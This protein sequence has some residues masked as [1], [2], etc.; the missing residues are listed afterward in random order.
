MTPQHAIFR[1]LFAE[2]KSISIDTYD[3]LPDFDSKYPFIYVGE[4]INTTVVNNDLMGQVAQTIHIYAERTQRKR[5]DQLITQLF[6][7]VSNLREVYEYNV[8]IRGIQQQIISDNSTN[9]I[10]LH[11]IIEISYF[12]TKKG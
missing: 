1:Q 12:Y 9:K 11:G 3:Y 10:L 2:C 8:S 4:A 5:L 6:N 7:I